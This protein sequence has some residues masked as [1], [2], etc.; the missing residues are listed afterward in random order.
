[1]QKVAG[2]KVVHMGGVDFMAAVDSARNAALAKHPKSQDCI[3]TVNI[4]AGHKSDLPDVDTVLPYTDYFLPSIEEAEALSGYRALRAVPNS[5]RTVV[6]SAAYS[7]WVEP[8]ITTAMRL[9]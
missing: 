8:A 2:G 4:F 6:S 9:R 5:F 1:M 7:R 3:T